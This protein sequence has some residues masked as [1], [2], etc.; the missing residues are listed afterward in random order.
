MNIRFHNLSSRLATSNRS[1]TTSKYSQSSRGSGRITLPSGS[2]GKR[3]QHGPGW[4]VPSQYATPCIP[5]LHLVSGL[6]ASITFSFPFLFKS[7]R[8]KFGSG[9]AGFISWAGRNGLVAG[10]KNRKTP[11]NL[12]RYSCGPCKVRRH[13]AKIWTDK[14]KS[15]KGKVDAVA[16]DHTVYISPHAPWMEFFAPTRGP[17]SREMDPLSEQIHGML[18]DR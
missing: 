2:R 14:R 12:R 7:L 8:A 15:E 1:K 16:I 11:E 13:S 3:L 6:A 5:S 4:Q 17:S 18:S 9:N 10:N